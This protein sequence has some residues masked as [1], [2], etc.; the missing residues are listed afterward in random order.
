[1]K[2]NLSR[3][4]QKDLDKLPNEIAFRISNKIFELID[5]PYLYGSQ[6][7]G[8]DKGYRIKIGDYR[9]VYTINKEN[10]EVTIIRVRH[11]KEVYRKLQ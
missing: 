3:S 6:K 4:A 2:L 8:E 7:L 1:M 10:K 9:I 11:R 5:N